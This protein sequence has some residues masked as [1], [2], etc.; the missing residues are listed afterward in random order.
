MTRRGTRGGAASA[1]AV[2]I[3]SVALGA[4]SAATTTPSATRSAT[5]A[6]PHR[7]G[8]ATTAGSSTATT[9][10]STTST[11]ALATANLVVTDEIRSELTAAGAMLD[12]LPASAYT[13]LRPGETY[14][15]YDAATQTY[16]ASGGLVPSASSMQA[17]VSTQDDGAYLLFSRPA[18]GAWKAYAVGLAGTTEGSPC[19]I[20]VPAAVLQ[21]WRWPPGS[22]RPATIS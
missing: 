9:S 5:T 11:A 12:S 16:W 2:V 6:A 15:A 19:P 18:G 4:C 17:Q 14:Y 1:A 8:T 20:A 21:L 3:V 7:S 10:P 22:C 13:G